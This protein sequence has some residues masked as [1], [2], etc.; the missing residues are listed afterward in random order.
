MI[1][2]RWSLW[3]GQNKYRTTLNGRLLLRRPR[4][5]QSCST[6][7]EEEEEYTNHIKFCQPLPISVTASIITVRLTPNI[8]IFFFVIQQHDMASSVPSAALDPSQSLL[9]RYT[10]MPLWLTLIKWYIYISEFLNLNPWRFTIFSTDGVSSVNLNA[11]ILDF[12]VMP[13]VWSVW[14]HCCFYGF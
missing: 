12:C 8:P 9:M 11:W 14:V 10:A 2:R 13:V 1:W 4:L 7:E 3:S 5:Y 6:I